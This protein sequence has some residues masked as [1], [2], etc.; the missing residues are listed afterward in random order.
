M[1]KRLKKLTITEVASCAKGINPEARVVFAKAHE[2]DIFEE[3]VIK[4]IFEDIFKKRQIDN[5]F[6][7]MK[8]ALS[9]GISSVWENASISI[10]DKKTKIEEIANSFVN[11]IGSLISITKSAEGG[12]DKKDSKEVATM[13]N[14]MIKS[15]DQAALEAEVKKAVDA[16]DTEIALLKAI[17]ELSDDEK[18]FYKSLDDTGKS[19]FLKK[20]QE[21]RKVDIKKS[22][23]GDEALVV[24][25]QI[26]RK[27]VVGDVMFTVVKSQ[28]EQIEKA[29]KAAAAEKDEREKLGYMQKAE[30]EFPN[31]PGAPELKAR[32][33]K[34][35]YA[36]PEQDVRESLFGVLKSANDG[37]N[38]LFT[39]IGTSQT[40]S[41]FTSKSSADKLDVLVKEHATKKGISVTK[42]YAEVL[43]TVEGQQLAKAAKG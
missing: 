19:S 32:V 2:P 40:N 20:S 11:A 24:N 29:N 41:M 15:Y 27:S 1:V 21:E 28:Q 10:E 25:G 7:D 8:Y 6:W 23:E 31:L 37:M 16:K 36:I 14:E 12:E 4:G 35:V 42:A 5:V 30:K 34:A 33:L 9:D 26:V 18:A 39:P 17:S 43:E 3:P 38:P 13:G 22:K